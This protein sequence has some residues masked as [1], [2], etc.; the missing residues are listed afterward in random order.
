MGWHSLRKILKKEFLVWSYVWT[1]F[2]G[3]LMCLES[4][5][6]SQGIQIISMSWSNM[7]P[8][9]ESAWFITDGKQLQSWSWAPILTLGD[10]QIVGL[11]VDFAELWKNSD[12]LGI[13]GILNI[14]ARLFSLPKRPVITLSS[15]IYEKESGCQC[16]PSFM[17]W[18]LISKNG[19]SQKFLYF[20]LTTWKLKSSTSSTQ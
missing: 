10:Y 4:W 8:W 9:K 13:G 17:H 6:K 3:H 14:C 16:S 7:G 2:T 19:Y 11:N 1:Y 12:N 20:T 5:H 18:T 15:F